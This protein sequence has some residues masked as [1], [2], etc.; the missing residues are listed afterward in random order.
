[1]TNDRQASSIEMVPLR[2]AANRYDVAIL[3]GGLAGLTLSIQLKRELPDASVAVLEKREGPAPLAAFKVG[4]STV[5]AGAH[6]FAEIVGMRTH[7][8]QRQLL[9]FGLRFLLPAGDNSDVTKRIEVGPKAFPPQD[10]F[11]IDRGLFEN[12]LA[13]RAR[14]LG[15]DV[16]QGCRVQEVGLGDPHKVTFTQAEA[17]TM[18]EARWVVDAC[19]RASF[20]KR[21]LGLA[22]EHRH[23]INASWLRLRG[24]L[25]WEQWGADNA[26]WM[27]EMPEPGLRQYSTTHLCGEGYWVWLIPLSSGPISI[28]V[29]ADPRFHPFEEINEL[30]GFI[31]WLQRNEPQLGR[32][33]DARRG[34][35][36]DFLRVEDFAFD[37][38]QAYSTDRWSLVGEAA[39]FADPF[40]SPGSDMIGYGNCMTTELIRRDLA[41]EDIAGA[42]E[43]CNGFYARTFESV[44]SRYTDLYGTF[45]HPAVMMPK[46]IFDLAVNHSA[47]VLLM[48]QNKIGDVEFM[49]SVQED[50][51]AMYRVNVNMQRLFREWH[52]L[53]EAFERELGGV[54]VRPMLE[55]TNSVAQKF[56]DD[57]LRAELRRQREATEALAI[58]I[59]EQASSVLDEAPDFS[60]PMSPAAVGLK[61]E[62]WDEEGLYDDGGLT[63]EQARE[64]TTFQ[65]PGGGPPPGVGGPP[66]GVGGPP[67]GVGGPPPG[68]GGPPPGVGGPPPGVGGPPGG[69]P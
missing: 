35:V 38:D 18:L 47:Q 23:T 9:K 43:W 2:T 67:P 55:A 37:V 53:E 48:T 65:F 17:D 33:V 21:K 34:D 16:L 28:G 68:V 40:Y 19:G 60:R 26:D 13:S 15:V 45:G 52:E 11:Q 57:G 12:E 63:L 20:L 25:D 64:R 39:A 59:F 6:Y 8:R 51:D 56:D 50:V 32:A 7:L 3:G 66:P 1:M 10:T 54:G 14:Q 30:D 29:C 44:V 69:K 42:V 62:R 4:E 49:E 36:E 22:K 5:P 46:L 31:A 61:P 41:G 27:G 58:T 24:G